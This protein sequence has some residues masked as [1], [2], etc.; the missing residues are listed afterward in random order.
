MV[1]VVLQLP[2]PPRQLVALLL[3]CITVHAVLSAAWHAP[4]HLLHESG[5][6]GCVK[7]AS[8]QLYCSCAALHA[9]VWEHQ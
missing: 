2:V 9:C 7:H 8:L 6:W 3:D 4:K 5:C 1:G